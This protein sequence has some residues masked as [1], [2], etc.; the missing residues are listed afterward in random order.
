MRS[1]AL[2]LGGGL[3][4]FF[5]FG[6]LDVIPLGAKVGVFFWFLLALIA[7]IYRWSLTEA[8]GSDQ[9]YGRQTSEE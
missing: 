8:L 1:S 6:F 9:N 7:A 4:A 2:G 5:V 3:L